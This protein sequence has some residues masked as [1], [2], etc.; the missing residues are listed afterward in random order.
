[1][2]NVVGLKRIGIVEDLRRF[3]KGHA[4]LLEILASFLIIPLKPHERILRY[5]C[6]ATR[7]ISRPSPPSRCVKTRK[8]SGQSVLGTEI[9]PKRPS[10]PLDFSCKAF[11]TFSG[12][13]GT[14]SMRTPTAL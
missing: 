4:M 5:E 10:R 13:S 9:G 2:L 1:M 6:T 12:V 3:S 8:G 11:K 14:S 7:G